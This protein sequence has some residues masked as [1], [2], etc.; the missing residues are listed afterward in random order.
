VRI[1]EQKGLPASRTARSDVLFELAD[2]VLCADGPVKTLVD[3]TLVT[4]H[5]RGHKAMYDL[6]NH[7]VLRQS[8][9][10]GRWHPLLLPRVRGRSDRAR[11]RRRPVAALGRTHQRGV[12]GT[13]QERRLCKSIYVRLGRA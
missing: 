13:Y 4:E 2:A 1:R 6:L 11:R 12:A 9:S 10:A 7:A 8:G 5:R 3:L